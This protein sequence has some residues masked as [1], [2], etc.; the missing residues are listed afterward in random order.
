MGQTGKGDSTGNGEGWRRFD[1]LSSDGLRLA[2]RKYGWE[3]DQWLPVVCLAG[4]TRN[5][6]D[7]HR[8][9]LHLSRD[10]RRP[11]R[12]LSLDYRGRGM[13]EYDKD[14][15]NYNVLTEADDV[16][17]G[18]T[19]AGIEQ[20]IFIGTSRGGLI[21]FVLAAMRP[22]SIAGVVLNDVGPEIDGRGLVRIRSYVE[23]SNDFANWSQAIETLKGAGASQFPE[24]SDE[25][26]ACQARLIFAERNGRIERRYDPRLSRTLTTI[27]L[28]N[29]LP[30]M[31]PQFRGLARVP[32]LAI[33]GA[34]SDLFSD[35]TLEK[36][37]KTHPDLEALTVPD[38]GHVP[39]LGS[40]GLP[41]KIAAF[42]ERAEGKA[43]P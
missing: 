22:G 31:W 12:V 25:D 14:W 43:K 3:H 19:A 26:W 40:G 35:A 38:Q 1:Y 39:D 5:S 16:L 11:R 7:F 15:H 23:K 36:M 37:R 2:G 33:R 20:A 24:W 9:A 34:N 28:D 30:D 21:C 13:S 6:A 27:N 42:A 10:A 41:A 17:A 18:L 29:R 32:V 4:L 8:L